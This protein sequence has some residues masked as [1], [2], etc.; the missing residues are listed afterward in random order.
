MAF[1]AGDGNVGVAYGRFAV[2]CGKE[3]VDVAVAIFTGSGRGSAFGRLGV[4]T[5]LV[6][7][8]GVAMAVGAGDLLGRRFVGQA[9]DVFMTIHAGEHAAVDGVRELFAIDGERDFLTAFIFG[10]SLIGVTGEAIL[11]L[12]L[13]LGARSIGN[14]KKEDK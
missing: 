4:E 8:L 9:R 13:V 11:I 2:V 1:A 7:L 12:E 10:Q 6:G 3:L 14:K 5:V